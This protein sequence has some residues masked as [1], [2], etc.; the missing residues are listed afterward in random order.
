MKRLY[1]KSVLTVH[2]QQ[3][4][5]CIRNG[6]AIAFACDIRAWL[7]AL[8]AFLLLYVPAWAQMPIT[9]AN[10]PQ[11]SAYPPRSSADVKPDNSQ[12]GIASGLNATQ[13]TRRRTGFPVGVGESFR[14]CAVCPEM[15]VI[16]PGRFVMG[17]PPAEPGHDS[18]ETPQRPIVAREP[19]AVGKF[20]VTNAEWNACVAARGCTT[21]N[22][23]SSPAEPDFPVVGVDWYDGQ[24]YVR[25]LTRLTGKTYR[26]LTEAEWEYT[27]RAGTTTA[28]PWGDIAS[29]EQANYSQSALGR[30]TTVGSYPPNAWGLHDMHGNVYEWVQDCYAHGYTQSKRRT[31][32]WVARNRCYERVIRGGS[33]QFKSDALRS[34]ART[35]IPTDD[36]LL[37][38]VVRAVVPPWHEFPEIGLRVA[39]TR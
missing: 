11:V 35:S 18:P 25:W 13:R 24:Q 28:Y 14:D 31:S 5:Q 34:S 38:A 23:P 4:R 26:L 39:R 20:E 1:I 29:P 7:S 16:P 37:R 3:T 27:A 12:L 17:S 30:T 32:D 9:P 2:A 33:W 6:P 36:G 10:M 21:P 15:V 19:L 8:F 22:S